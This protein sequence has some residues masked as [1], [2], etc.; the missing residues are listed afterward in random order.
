MKSV[1]LF[2]A[3]VLLTLSE[4]I[5]VDGQENSEGETNNIVNAYIH[6][7]TYL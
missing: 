3:V 7:C 4:K 2:F 6:T 5:L 1:K